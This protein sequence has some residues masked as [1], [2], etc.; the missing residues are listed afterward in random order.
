M[1]I[2]NGFYGSSY[3][4]WVGS[5]YLCQLVVSLL[6]RDCALAP[7]WSGYCGVRLQGLVTI[8]SFLYLPQYSVST[9]EKLGYD[10][11]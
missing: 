10:R 3:V 1:I 8:E 2:S 6:G 9:W 7:H 4:I 5:L 11:V